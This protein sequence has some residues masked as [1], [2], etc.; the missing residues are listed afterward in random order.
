MM[1]WLIAQT[2]YAMNLLITYK[3]TF[4]IPAVIIGGFLLNGLILSNNNSQPTLEQNNQHSLIPRHDWTNSQPDGDTHRLS[5]TLILDEKQISKLGI[6]TET[7]SPHQLKI[8]LDLPGEI[9]LNEDLTSHITPPLPGLVKVLAV[10]LGDVVKKDQLLVSISST[11]IAEK[12][13]R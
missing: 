1:T 8:L 10:N 6:K 11:V 5:S 2:G 9:R 12:A 3:Q 7:A 13:A 4:A